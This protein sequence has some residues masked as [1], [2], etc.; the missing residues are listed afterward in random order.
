MPHFQQKNYKAHQER[1]KY[2]SFKGKKQ[3]EHTSHEKDL[4]VDL[5]DNNFKMS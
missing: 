1:G 5:L 3:V 4:I 2:G